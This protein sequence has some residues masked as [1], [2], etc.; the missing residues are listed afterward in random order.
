MVFF[1]PFIFIASN[2]SEYNVNYYYRKK[3]T[4][5]ASSGDL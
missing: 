4:E 5:V 1:C 3:N 2:I